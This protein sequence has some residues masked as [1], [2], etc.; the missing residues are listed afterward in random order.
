MVGTDI[1]REFIELPKYS[2]RN[3]SEYM[4]NPTALSVSQQYRSLL[5]ALKWLSMQEVLHLRF[6]C[7]QWQLVCDC[8]EIW[9]HFLVCLG[10]L[11]PCMGKPKAV[12][13]E[14]Y[15][16]QCL[17]LA[18]ETIVIRYYPGR[19]ESKYT[20]L[21]TL[22]KG[23][24]ET[25]LIDNDT[26][27]CCAIDRSFVIS[28]QTGLV[29]PKAPMVISRT[30]VGLCVLKSYIYA[31]CGAVGKIATDVC[32]RFSLQT[33]HWE[34]LPHAQ[35]PRQSFNPAIHDGLIYLSGG[36]SSSIETFNPTSLLFTLLP[37]TSQNILPV[38]SLILRDTLYVFN[39]CLCFWMNCKTGQNGVKCS[40]FQVESKSAV[41][42]LIWGNKSII[43]TE[44]RE[45]WEV[46]LEKMSY[47]V[48]PAYH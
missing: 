6:S 12:Y 5:E 1:I 32:E 11:G 16:N 4:R 46:D 35:R 27:F 40:G 34:T 45:V 23:S 21:Q 10:Y 37:V 33:D 19:K 41:Q 29:Q 36:S 48:L 17:A 2:L 18:E 25:V 39:S 43:V 3:M 14:A 28:L 20:N 47:Q 42:P 26:L 31:L 30:S 13:K 9:L 44:K 22:L 15:L 38:T 7:K 24:F 8:D